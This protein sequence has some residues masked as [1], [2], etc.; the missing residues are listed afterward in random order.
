VPGFLEGRFAEPEITIDVRRLAG[1]AGA[2]FVEGEGEVIDPAGAVVHSTAGAIPFTHLS[3]DIGSAP[4]GER[5]PGV[6]E[7]AMT[8][9]PM[10]RVLEL[11]DRVDTLAREGGGRMAIVGGGAGAVEIALALLR[12]TAGRQIGIDVVESG[13]R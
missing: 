11:A 13:S 3:L 2:D 8:L 9:R 4:A 7:L 12:R 10:S 1:A 5:L 6:A